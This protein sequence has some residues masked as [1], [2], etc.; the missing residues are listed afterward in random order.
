MHDDAI[1]DAELIVASSTDGAR[2][3]EVFD[4]H[5]TAMLRFFMR[6]T[7]DAQTSADLM[8]ETFAA[9]FSSRGRFRDVGAPGDAWLYGIARR[10]LSRYHRRER[11]D[12]RARVRLGVP[13]ADLGADDIAR[14]EQLADFAPMRRDLASALGQLPDAQAEAV[15]LRV[16]LDL[17]YPEVAQRLGCS[18][19]AARVRVSRALVRL[20]ELMEDRT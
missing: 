19:G 7:G 5:A 6:R 12:A 10:Q 3:A 2:F 15:R 20:A 16:G 8:A 4:R 1:S 14:V 13:A 11:V 17:S 9:A 18:E